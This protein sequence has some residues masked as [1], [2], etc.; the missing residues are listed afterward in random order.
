MKIVE[1]FVIPVF[2]EKS[3]RWEVKVDLSKKRYTF[4]VSYNT[5]CD[6]W[7][8]SILDAE[9]NLL[10]AGLRLV[11]G[12]FL[13]GKYRASVPELPPGELWLVDVQSKLSTAEVTRNN[14]HSRFALTYTV[15]EE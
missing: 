2:S 10:L 1:S 14:L 13:L 15:F 4:Y 5:R 11:P 6:A 8:L 3:S 12:V 9:N 7:F